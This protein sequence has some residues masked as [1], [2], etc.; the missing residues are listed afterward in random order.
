MCMQLKEY[1]TPPKL[2]ILNFVAC[3]LIALGLILRF[4]VSAPEDA[5]IGDTPAF[6]FIV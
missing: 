1:F 4:I 3:G 6:L 5:G 2:R